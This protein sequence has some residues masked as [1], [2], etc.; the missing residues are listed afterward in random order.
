MQIKDD[1]NRRFIWV[2]HIIQIMN[3]NN[4][5]EMKFSNSVISHDLI[6]KF[7]SDLLER[8]KSYGEGKKLRT[9]CSV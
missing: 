9:Y 5:K 8:I 7:K 3:E 2:S 4:I 6:D 1:G